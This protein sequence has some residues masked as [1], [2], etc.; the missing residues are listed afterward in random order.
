MERLQLE[1]HATCPRWN[2]TIRPHQPAVTAT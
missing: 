1:R 2:Y